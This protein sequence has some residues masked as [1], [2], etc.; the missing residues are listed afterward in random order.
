MSATNPQPEIDSKISFP[1]NQLPG[2]RLTGKVCQVIGLVVEASGI[3][4]FI[5]GSAALKP[6]R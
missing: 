3:R 5:G 2:G 4:P 1:G 6:G